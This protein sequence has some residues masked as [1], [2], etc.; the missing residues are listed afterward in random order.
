VS[1]VLCADLSCSA[2]ESTVSLKGSSLWTL[3]LMRNVLAPVVTRSCRSCTVSRTRSTSGVVVR[4]ARVPSPTHFL[5]VFR[6]DS[7]SVRYI[8]SWVRCVFLRR[9]PLHTCLG[10]G[11]LSVFQLPYRSSSLFLDQFGLGYIHP[12]LLSFC[13]GIVGLVEV[14]HDNR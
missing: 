8:R 7:M 5:M 2:L 13:W 4:F 1:S 14:Y 9:L 3:I 6:R 12:S 10:I 11:R